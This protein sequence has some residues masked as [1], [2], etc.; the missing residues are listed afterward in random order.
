MFAASLLP[1]AVLFRRAFGQPADGHFLETNGK[2]LAK[3]CQPLDPLL[4][5][6]GHQQA[7]HCDKLGG[8]YQIII[9]NPNFLLDNHSVTLFSQK[10]V[11]MKKF[12]AFCAKNQD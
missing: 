3:F 6:D 10:A 12:D 7:G 11:D 2:K 4:P 5:G 9:K 1:S 8:C